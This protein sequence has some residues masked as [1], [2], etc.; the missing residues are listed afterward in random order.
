M[1][2]DEEIIMEGA[3]GEDRVEHPKELSHKWTKSM[4]GLEDEQGRGLPGERGVWGLMLSKN[5]HNKRV[6]Q[7]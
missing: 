5:C 7:L 1:P 2:V 3:V 4:Q 6:R